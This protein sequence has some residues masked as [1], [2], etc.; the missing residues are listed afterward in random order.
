MVKATLFNKYEDHGAL[1]LLNQPVE[2]RHVPLVQLQPLADQA[3][4]QE[5]ETAVQV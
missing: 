5:R 1:D 2:Q 3:K 4:V